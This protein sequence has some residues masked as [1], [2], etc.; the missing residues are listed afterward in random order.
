MFPSV[1]LKCHFTEGDREQELSEG[2]AAVRAWAAAGDAARLAGVAPR[3]RVSGC[4]MGGSS[5]C[6]PPPSCEVVCELVCLE[7]TFR[8]TDDPKVFLSLSKVSLL[9]V[10]G[11]PAT[12]FTSFQLNSLSPVFSPSGDPANPSVPRRIRR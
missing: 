2:E 6:P 5:D 11:L 4:R 12:I 7:K 8:G 10:P 9:S 3:R 1:K